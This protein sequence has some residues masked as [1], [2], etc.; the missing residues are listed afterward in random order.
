MGEDSTTSML[1]NHLKSKHIAIYVKLFPEEVEKSRQKGKESMSD[2][3]MLIS[4]KR[5]C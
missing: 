1:K 2:A 5:V 4:K 3:D